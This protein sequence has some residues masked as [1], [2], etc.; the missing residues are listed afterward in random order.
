MVGTMSC[1]RPGI[2]L[3]LVA[4]GISPWA[5]AMNAVCGQLPETVTGRVS[6]RDGTPL[7][8]MDVRWVGTNVTTVSGRNGTFV[9]PSVE[10]VSSVLVIEGLGYREARVAVGENVTMPLEIEVD[11][12]PV[13]L[14]GLLVEGR[15][16]GQAMAMQQQ[17][18][19]SNM[20]NVV[21]AERIG[22]FPDPNA[23]EALQRLPGISIA[24][25]QGEGRYV[26]I[27]GSDPRLSS[28]SING[29]RLPAPEGQGRRVALD[30]I[31]ADIL[32]GIEV[33]KSVTPDMDGD[34]IG[35]AVNLVTRGASWQKDQVNLTVASGFNALTS[36]DISQVA[37]NLSRRFGDERRIG[38]VLAGSYYSTDRGSDNIELK[39]DEGFGARV[40]DDLQFRDYSVSRD[41]VGL[42]GMV[43]YTFPDDRSSFSLTG[44]FNDFADQEFRRMARF[45]FGKGD[46]H[47]PTSITDAEMERELRDR[48][49]RQRIWVTT[50][51]GSQALGR[52][53]LDY[54][55]SL[56]HAEEEEP[57]RSDMT[58]LQEEMGFNLDLTDPWR[59][60][61]TITEGAEHDYGAF[62]FGE[63]VLEDNYTGENA[64]VASVD[65]S[66]PFTAWGHSSLLKVG[67]KLRRSDKRQ[68]MNV[69]VYD[70]FEGDLALD[71][72][73]GSFEDSGFFHRQ[74]RVGSV[75]GPD[76]TREFRT[77]NLS[78]FELDESS[79]RA[80][81]DPANY[82]ADELISAMYILAQA[83]LGKLRVIPGIRFEKTDLSYK[84]NEV[85][86]DEEGEFLST[87]P[88]SAQNHEV[89]AL[90]GVTLRYRLD[91]LTNIRGAVTRTL[92]RPDYFDLVP[93]RLINREDEEIEMGNDA[94]RST[95]STNV[96]LAFE[97]FDQSV[98]LFST[99]LF[100]KDLSRY[101]Y[102]RRFDLGQGDDLEGFQGIRPENGGEGHL[103]GIEVGWSRQLVFLPGLL[104]GLNL[105]ANYTF[106]DSHMEYEGREGRFVLPGQARHVG[107]VALGYD[108][109][110]WSGRVSINLH[111]DFVQ[112][113]GE[114]PEED[115]RYGSHTQVDLSASY[116]LSQR[117]Q[118]F[119]EAI[120][121]T[122]Q[123]L[124]VFMNDRRFPIQ[125]EYYSWWGHLGVKIGMR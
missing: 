45:R 90:P 73:A 64:Q 88:T 58:M 9:L 41:R 104:D 78:S 13:L 40:L 14:D 49:E 63:L 82:R 75:P 28:V 80:D 119:F 8:G 92:A 79:S 74:Y 18:S 110:G 124:S 52:G 94:L 22:R 67:G 117:A 51:V 66:L 5:G 38:V 57:G 101:V 69:R 43:E 32:G 65:W 46:Y 33:H 23:A 25:D 115:I 35:G 21:S 106:T 59:P 60:R 19:S 83:D 95:T 125:Q 53:T 122:N 109:H 37:G 77:Q 42:M 11:P 62:E 120:N 76:R 34:A 15:R 98:G 7:P 6:N 111:G 44:V 61:Y 70:G 56:S 102:R 93:Y 91:P 3:A 86:F 84:G 36:R 85:V 39:W 4:M 87:A 118:L 121:I 114:V 81:T 107:N 68:A 89:H 71:A 108:K 99:G 10:T 17:R 20:K 54:S 123:P 96:D 72:L 31:P 1:S 116:Q 26:L 105:H 30:V 27:R 24:R 50:A 113:V 16:T 47:S 12:D 112:E 2:I 103:W 29:A 48:F 100:Y 55:L 97:R